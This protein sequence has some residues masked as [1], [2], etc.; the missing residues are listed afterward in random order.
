MSYHKILQKQIKRH[1]PDDIAHNKNVLS[2]LEEINDFYKSEDLD[3][4]LSSHA[5]EVSEREYQD[6]LADISTKNSILQQAIEQ[7]KEAI[8]TLKPEKLNNQFIG[9]DDI[10]K[11]ISFL[12]SLIVESKE[13]EKQIQ[14]NVNYLEKLDKVNFAVQNINNEN[15]IKNAYEKI[16]LLGLEIFQCQ[17]IFIS[18]PVNNDL[19]ILQIVMDCSPNEQPLFYNG[20]KAIQMN[21]ELN[22]IIYH[23]QLNKEYVIGEINNLPNEIVFSSKETVVIKS[24]ICIPLKS[25]KG[26]LS[27]LGIFHENSKDEWSQSDKKL[28][29][30][31]SDKFSLKLN[32]ILLTEELQ[33]SEAQYKSLLETTDDIVVSYDF[34]GNITYVN[35]KGLNYFG[36]RPDDYIGKNV[37]E[38]IPAEHKEQIIE[39]FN[40]RKN[41]LKTPRIIE[42][43][44]YDK[45]R[46][47]YPFEINSS[48]TDIGDGNIGVIAFVRDVYDRKNYENQLLEQNSELKKI[49]QELDRFVYS[50]SHDLRAPLTSVLGLINISKEVANKEDEVY[51]FLEMMEGSILNLDNVIRSILEYS[52][53]NRLE[54]KYDVIDVRGIYDSVLESLNYMY[55]TKEINHIV[56]INSSEEFISD[57]IR[58]SSI[59]R[60]LI[61]NAIKYSRDIKD[62]FVK[63]SFDLINGNAV[64]VIEDNGIGIS[65]KSYKKIFEMFYR[66]T[67]SATG[68]G[69]GLYIVKQSVEKLNGKIELE[70]ELGVGSKFTVTIPN[71]K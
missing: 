68:N 4:K 53:S 10:T 16:L 9:S 3:K 5:S 31:I 7:L 46:T 62:S 19:G 37:F 38:F 25:A 24:V 66:D 58:V 29:N 30:Q 23:T 60:N 39:R 28:F 20:G 35:S 26:Q 2:F 61:T 40:E 67:S 48:L 32:T 55:T 54:V 70:S 47:K 63:F 41:G 65:E 15:G 59:I 51:E 8:N 34:S 52:K 33:K 6:A 64:I 71:T 43:E 12:I 18:K 45:H 14:S 56:S 42:L 1:L 57:E 50:T 21:N 49:N 36:L 69:L 22:E 11:I 13:L 17:Y 44:L 27:M